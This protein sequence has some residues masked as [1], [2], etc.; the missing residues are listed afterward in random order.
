MLAVMEEDMVVEEMWRF[1]SG[2]QKIVPLPS[3]GVFIGPGGY[4]R[5]LSL[6]GTQ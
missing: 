1:E 6:A 4:V 3:V 5:L 2:P